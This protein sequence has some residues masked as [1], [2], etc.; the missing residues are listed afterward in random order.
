MWNSALSESLIS[1]FH[2]FL[3]SIEKKII[4]VENWALVY[5]SCKIW[6]FSDFS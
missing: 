5:N 4:L 6:N 1:T 3:A 2:K